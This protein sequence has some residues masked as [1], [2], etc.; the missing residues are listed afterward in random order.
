MSIGVATD[1]VRTVTPEEQQKRNPAMFP[2]ISSIQWF[3]RAHREELAAKGAVISP[4][5]RK[6]LVQPVFDQVVIEIGR[7]LQVEK[8]SR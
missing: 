3:M 4:T 7:R 2:S 1:E 6:L 8:V 5:G